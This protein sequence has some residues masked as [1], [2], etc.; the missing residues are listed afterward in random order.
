LNQIWFNEVTDNRGN[1]LASGDPASEAG[2]PSAGQPRRA[3]HR[4]RDGGGNKGLIT[5]AVKLLVHFPAIAGRISGGQL[6]QLEMNDDA[7][8]RF[9]FDLI[10]QLQQEPAAHTAQLLERWRDRPEVA[11]MQALAAEELLGHDEASATLELVAA[12]EKLSL[13]PTLRRLD[14]LMSKGDLT[15]DE[16]VELKELNVTIHRAKSRGVQNVSGEGSA[17]R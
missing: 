3:I 17:G 16:R 13:E 8:S 9:L 6:S 10:D 12:I 5:K 2:L 14:E 1:H 11:R 15:E 4:P 7:G